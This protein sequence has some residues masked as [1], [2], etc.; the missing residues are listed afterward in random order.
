MDGWMEES[1]DD[2]FALPS[3]ARRGKR[4]PPRGNTRIFEGPGGPKLRARACMVSVGVDEMVRMI[5][6]VKEGRARVFLPSSS[7]FDDGARKHQS[8]HPS[9]RRRHARHAM[10]SIRIPRGERE[11][12]RAARRREGGLGGV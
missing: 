6:F 10:P 2:V 3:T 11:K 5:L 12:A 8:I 4:T 9:R 1:Q 7:S